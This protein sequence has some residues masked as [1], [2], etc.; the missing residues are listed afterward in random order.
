MFRPPGRAEGNITPPGASV[1]AS[2]RCGYRDRR[3]SMPRRSSGDSKP[4]SLAMKVSGNRLRLGLV[5]GLAI[6]GLILLLPL[7]GIHAQSIVTTIT[8]GAGPRG[9]A[10]NTALNRAYVANNGAN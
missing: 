2:G 9:V 7:Q 1:T 10:V 6:T 3:K 5:V 8:V 4:G